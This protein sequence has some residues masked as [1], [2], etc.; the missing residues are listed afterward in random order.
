MDWAQTVNSGIEAQDGKNI[1]M[2]FR[3]DARTLEEIEDCDLSRISHPFG[4]LL[5]NHRVAVLDHSY[6][7]SEQLVREAV[8]TIGGERWAA[9]VIKRVMCGLLRMRTKGNSAKM[10]KLLLAMHRAL[11]EH[12]S[13]ASVYVG[14]ALLDLYLETGRL[15]SAEELLESMEMPQSPDRDYYAFHYYKGLVQ[16]CGER[17]REA[18][19]SLETAFRYKKSRG[20]VAPVYFVS[21]LLVG[22]FPRAAYLERFGCSYLQELVLVLRVGAY[23]DVD[24]AVERALAMLRDHNLRMVI[25]AHCPLVCFSSLVCRVYQQHGCDNKLA[26]E[27]I[28]DSLPEPCFKEIVCLLSSV[29]GF[30]RLR[31]YISIARRVVVFSRADP[32]PALAK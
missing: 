28:A 11:A 16:M 27:R 22:K 26:I 12:E 14:N 2:L 23:M 18:Y 25:S 19:M 21:S 10:S 5:D 24:D 31:G 20:V 7:A 15:G 4:M 32:F 17:F 3:T 30:G 6:D 8:H 29:I 9:P 1:S 13:P